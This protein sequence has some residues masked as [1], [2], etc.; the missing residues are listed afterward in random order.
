MV[1]CILIANLHQAY[2][3]APLCSP[4]WSCTTKQKFQGCNVLSCQVIAFQWTVTIKKKVPAA[5]YH[6]PWAQ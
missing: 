3:Q 1:I 4:Q 5:A 6:G 2:S